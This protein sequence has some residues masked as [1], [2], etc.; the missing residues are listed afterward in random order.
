ME[1]P[2]SKVSKIP[3]TNLINKNTRKQ[4]PLTLKKENKAHL[5]WVNKSKIDTHI[6]DMQSW[7][8]E[9]VEDARQKADKKQPV[10]VKSIQTWLNERY[11][12]RSQLDH[13]MEDYPELKI[14]V[15][16]TRAILGELREIVV[17]HGNINTATITASWPAYCP[18]ARDIEIFRAEQKAKAQ[19][20]QQANIVVGIP[21]FKYP[22]VENEKVLSDGNNH[23]NE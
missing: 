16:N 2:K 15:A 6:K 8:F 18:E 19:S 17:A 14:A 4:R 5:D 3:N 9:Q 7:A 20:A 12:S 21:T 13:W 11:I 23:N 1:K 10:I 22:F